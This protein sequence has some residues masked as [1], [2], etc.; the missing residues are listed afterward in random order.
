MEVGIPKWTYLLLP[1]G[2]SVIS[3]GEN[4]VKAGTELVGG[5][6]RRPTS[7]KP[8]QSGCWFH[9]GCAQGLCIIL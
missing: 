1:E 9:P 6:P 5:E 7:L 8:D 3:V 2:S 4:E